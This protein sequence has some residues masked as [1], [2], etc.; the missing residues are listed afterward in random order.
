MGVPLPLMVRVRVLGELALE[1]PTTQ[2]ADV[3]RARGELC[4]LQWMLLESAFVP[5]AQA[6]FDEGARRLDEA[7][8]ISEQLGDLLA[9]KP[10]VNARGWL[11]RSRRNYAR[12]VGDASGLGAGF[13]AAALEEPA[14]AGAPAP[15]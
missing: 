9:R 13:R 10:I 7:L 12:S 14:A 5:G 15:S 11:E 6:R 1:E 3:L 4:Y 8:R 2:L